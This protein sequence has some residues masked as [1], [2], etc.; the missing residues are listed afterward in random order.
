MDSFGYE[1]L[2]SQLVAV[3][4]NLVLSLGLIIIGLIGLIRNKKIGW[5]LLGTTG[6]IY[7][8]PLSVSLYFSLGYIVNRDHARSPEIIES[9]VLLFFFHLTGFLVFATGL[10][11]ILMDLRKQAKLATIDHS[12]AEPHIFP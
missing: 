1:M 4:P 12:Q 7:L 2:F 9:G 11:L 8:I 3:T 5:A 10:I 6:L